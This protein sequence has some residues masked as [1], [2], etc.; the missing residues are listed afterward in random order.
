METRGHINT[1]KEKQKK[2]NQ[3]RNEKRVEIGETLYWQCRTQLH[4]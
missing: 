2:K 1:Q 3:E 4:A